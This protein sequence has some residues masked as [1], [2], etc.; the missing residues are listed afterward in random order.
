VSRWV[1]VARLDELE[2]GVV[3][4]LV[5]DA[6]R[7]AV[8]RNGSEVHAVGDR[9]SHLGV[10]LSKGGPAT[11]GRLACWLHGSRFDLRSG[12]PLEPPATAALPVHQVVVEGDAEGDAI[13]LVDL[14]PRLPGSR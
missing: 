11:A 7:L 1:R 13:V 14:E 3:Y 9:C 12:R 5:V 4:Q 8:V 2:E 10:S 6:V